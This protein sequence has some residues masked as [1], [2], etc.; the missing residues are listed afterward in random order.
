MVSVYGQSLAFFTEINVWTIQRDV[1]ALTK[2]DG[3]IL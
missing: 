3:S 1:V 2:V